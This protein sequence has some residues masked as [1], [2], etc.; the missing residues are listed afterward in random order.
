MNRSIRASLLTLGLALAGLIAPGMASAA[1]VSIVS[2]VATFSAA[3][4][5]TNHLTIT[6]VGGGWVQFYDSGVTTMTAGSGCS[7]VTA[8]KVD[9]P[10]ASADAYSV[11]LGDGNDYVQDNLFYTSTTIYGGAGNDTIT[12]GGGN[13]TISGGAGNDTINGSGGDDTIDGDGGAD[14]ISGGTGVDTVTYATRPAPVTV[15][16]GDSL[17]NDGEA[18]EGDNLDATVENVVGGSGGDHLTG[19]AGANSLVGGAGDDV[20]VGGGGNDTLDGGT[21][22][23]SFDG[24]AGIDT[25][26]ARDTI[27]E[28][29]ACGSEADAVEADYNDVVAADC[30]AVDRSAAPPVA[31]PPVD[32]IIPPPPTGNGD[33]VPPIVAAI[34]SAPAALSPDGVVAVKLACPREA[35]EGCEGTVAIELLDGAKGTPAKAKLVS[36]RRRKVT[37]SR[38]RFKIAAGGTATVPVK[39]DRRVFRRFRGRRNVKA[40]VTVTMKNATGTTTTT[41]VIALRRVFKAKHRK[42]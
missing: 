30:E 4:G 38:K 19:S 34:S 33:V 37:Q 35:F 12:G 1:T 17:A 28:S 27:A 5:E 15:T 7:P 26:K 10:G 32:P 2:R 24:G 36:A 42:K 11:D 6:N 20:L 23:D 31:P 25:I 21:G 18:G 3:T 16:I 22:T 40:A 41:R 13:D 39:L 29:V 9:C 8:Q 14:A